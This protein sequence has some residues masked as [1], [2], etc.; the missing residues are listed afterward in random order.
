[1]T[2]FDRQVIQRVTAIA[3]DDCGR[4]PTVGAE[5]T[6]ALKGLAGSLQGVQLT[7]QIDVPQTPVTKTVDGGSCTKP[8]PSP[9]DRGYSVQLQFCGMN[10]VFESLTG[11]KT[12]DMAGANVTG[13]EDIE[14]T[15]QSKV[16][17]EI[18]FTPSADSCAGGSVQCYGL[19]LPLCEQWVRSGDETYDGETVPDLIV[20]GQTALNEHLFDNYAQGS[21]PAWLDHW[22][23][24][25][26]D[27]QLGRAWSTSRLITCPAA[28]SN[29]PCVLVAI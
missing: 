4:I 1:M 15:T 2:C 7:R 22:D 12:L 16:A 5:P 8:R 25:H 18:V 29:D 10:P 9:T 27:I 14:I 24:K 6:P 3:L 26:A 19:L 17:I 11:Y 23:P 28:D 13:W 21:L 20:T